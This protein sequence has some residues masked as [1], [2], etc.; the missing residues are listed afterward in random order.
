MRSG[1]YTSSSWWLCAPMS[2]SWLLMCIRLCHPRSKSTWR[3]LSEE[4]CQLNIN[5]IA[6]L[7][8]WSLAEPQ[9]GHSLSLTWRSTACISRSLKAGRCV[10]LYRMPQ[11]DQQRHRYVSAAFSFVWSLSRH[12]SS[13]VAVQ[14]RWSVRIRIR[15][16][17]WLGADGCRK[18]EPVQHSLLDE[19]YWSISSV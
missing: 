9:C 19:W 5:W 2:E 10:F 1:P 13:D 14:K 17:Q 7:T 16:G 11:L 8:T 3:V 6:L 4:D 18:W 12:Y 15:I